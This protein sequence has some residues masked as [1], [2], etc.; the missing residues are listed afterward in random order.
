MCKKTA[1]DTASPTD[2]VIGIAD[3]SEGVRSTAVCPDTMSDTENVSEAIKATV[4][5]KDATGLHASSP[6]SMIG[7]A[8]ASK[9]IGST[10]VVKDATSPFMARVGED[11]PQHR[12][13]TQSQKKKMLLALLASLIILAGVALGV[14]LGVGLHK[15]KPHQGLSTGGFGE[16]SWGIGC[17]LGRDRHCQH[18]CMHGHV[19][20][21]ACSDVGSQLPCSRVIIEP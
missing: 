3:L 7:I 1:A 16:R 9:D 17:N 2:T 12:G 8:G 19:H 20:E 13:Y 4:V 10:A 6:D 18:A 14:G 5:F 21:V 15:G 11:V